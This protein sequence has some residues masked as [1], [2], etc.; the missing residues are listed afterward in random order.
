M[1]V[2]KYRKR[3]F[4]SDKHESDENIIYRKTFIEKPFALELITCQRVHL[5]KNTAKEKEKT[6]TDEHM[7]A[8]VKSLPQINFE[9]I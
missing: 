1:L 7:N 3:F 8:S 5:G 2:F 9:K 6:I 4:F